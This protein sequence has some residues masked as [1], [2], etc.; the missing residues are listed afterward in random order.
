LRFW[1]AK[2]LCL[3]PKPYRERFGEGMGQTFND[4]LRER[5]EQD[6]G[7][8]G[9]ALWMFVETSAGIVGENMTSLILHNKRILGMMLAIA[10][11]LLIPLVAMQFTDEVVWDLFDFIVAGVLLVGAALSYEVVARRTGDSAYRTAVGVA[12]AAALILVWVN[13]AVGLIG[14]EDNPANL[15]YGGVLAV[16]LIGALIARFRPSGMSRALYAMAIAQALVPV[17]ALIIGKLYV[18][19]VDELLYVL[20][21]FGVNAV[22][23]ML[24]VVSA[25]LFRR[26]SVTG[27]QSKRQVE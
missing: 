21:V 15:M 26:A 24:F 27:S 5:A 17:I 13:G 23:A 16:G 18:T 9:Y 14:S 7:L 6:S 19:S 8:V 3:Y 25:V 12:V 2:L 22:F 10:C 11:I 4:L 20:R 1:Y